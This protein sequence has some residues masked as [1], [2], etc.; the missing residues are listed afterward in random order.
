MDQERDLWG[1]PVL[2]AE[3]RRGRPK[4]LVTDETRFRVAC[5]AMFRKTEREIAEAMGISGP[6]L[7]KYYRRELEGALAQMRAKLLVELCRKAYAGDGSAMKLAFK[8][9]E[10]SDMLE[11]RRLFDGAE[12]PV[13]KG[14]R[15]GKKEE[16][17]EAAE[18]AGD[19]TDWA[20]DLRIFPNGQAN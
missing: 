9:L 10:K 15:R 20:D 18:N 17:A 8:E 14:P 3:E 13:A 2:P 1:D 11:A 6:T 4:H 12:P 19:G 5:L 7:R 16:A